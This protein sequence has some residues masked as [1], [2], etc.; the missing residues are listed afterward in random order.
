MK[1]F[2]LVANFSSLKEQ[3]ARCSQLHY[4]LNAPRWS[5]VSC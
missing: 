1:K 2:T 4:F 3:N 5:W